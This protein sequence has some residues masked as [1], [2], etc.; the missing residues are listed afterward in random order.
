MAH[1]LHSVISYPFRKSHVFLLALSWVLGLKFSN[2]LFGIA[3]SNLAPQMP[4]A[5]MSQPSIFGLLTSFWLPFLFSAWA[6]YISAPKLLYLIAFVNAIPAGLFCSA[7]CASFGS[8]GWLVR[9]LL[10][11]TDICGTV[12]LFHYWLRHVSGNRFF[13]AGVLCRYLAV[14]I[15]F[16]AVDYCFVSPLLQRCLF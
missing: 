11:F 8:A 9:F 5:A 15:C 10:L 16:A 6:V 7:V 14:G 12:F 2:Y 1:F 4:L 13:S 3:G